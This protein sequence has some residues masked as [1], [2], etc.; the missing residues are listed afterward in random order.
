MVNKNSLK[1][2][3]ENNTAQILQCILK[4]GSI[5]RIELAEVLDLSPSTVSQ[6]VASLLE[7]GVI[8]E[9]RE[10]ESTGG[11]KPVIIRISPQYGCV[12]TTEITRTGVTAKVYDLQNQLLADSKIA[13]RMLTGNALLSTISGYIEAV[14]SGNEELPNRVIGL[15]LLCQDDIPNYDL[16]TEFS[17]SLASDVI[18]LETAISIRCNIPVKKELI[19]RYSLDYYLKHDDVKCSSYA[20]VDLGERLTAS[21]LINNVPVKN[22]DDTVFDLSSFVLS[23]KS[24]RAILNSSEMNSNRNLAL[25]Q[26]MAFRKLSV[27]E[28]VDKLIQLFESALLFFPVDN[29]FI[30][31]QYE[32]LDTIVNKV[33][34]KFNFSPVVRKAHFEKRNI[35]N[36]FAQQILLDNYRSLL[37]TR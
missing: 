26:N 9:F 11:R 34:S 20:Y 29:I 23:G 6:A 27:D 14:K 2:I 30:G 12:I 10:G 24:K 25:A 8:E 21:F 18:S 17:T 3:K 16:T 22:M 35:T 32:G 5:S 4:N 13:T 1:D 28:L 15:G 33:A 19:N 31:G 37:A 7:E 36:V